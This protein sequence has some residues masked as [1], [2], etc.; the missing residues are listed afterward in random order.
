MT[1]LGSCESR[2]G[3]NERSDGVFRPD[4]RASRLTQVLLPATDD[5]GCS[6][7]ASKWPE[8]LHGAAGT[9]RCGCSAGGVVDFAGSPFDEM[10]RPA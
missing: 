6:F 4:A 3:V 2:T 8:S 1:R 10:C 7:L 9:C 5:G